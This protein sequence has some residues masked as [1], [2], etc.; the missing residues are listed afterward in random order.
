MGKFKGR[1]VTEWLKDTGDDRL[2]RLEEDFIFDDDNGIRWIA[3]KGNITDGASIPRAFWSLMG[4]PLAGKYRRA[5]VIHD[6]YCKAQD[7]PHRAVHKM[8]YEAMLADG[9]GKIKAKT[10]YW[11]VKTFGPKWASIVEG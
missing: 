7:R 1:V 6:V 8:F 3:T 9:V 2:M 5:A 4:G 10:M 11:A